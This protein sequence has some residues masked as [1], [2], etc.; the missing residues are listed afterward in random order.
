[1]YIFEVAIINLCL[2]QARSQTMNTLDSAAS[3]ASAHTYIS[4]VTYVHN[5]LL[6]IYIYSYVSYVADPSGRA[7]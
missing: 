7:V 6:H 1:M 4:Y 5:A 2:T 3:S